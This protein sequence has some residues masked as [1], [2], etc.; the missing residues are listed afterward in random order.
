MGRVAQYAVR[1]MGLENSM[2]IRYGEPMD[3]FGNSVGP[4]GRSY[5]PDGTVIDPRGYF[6]IDGRATADAQRDAEYT[7]QTGH[8]V[9]TAFLRETVILPSNFL[10]WLLFEREKR[11][12]P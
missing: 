6:T 3:V 8:A 2:V 4:C 10:G 11:L 7:R 9:A 12:A 5:A 1:V